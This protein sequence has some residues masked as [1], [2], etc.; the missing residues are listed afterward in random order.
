MLHA[1]LNTLYIIWENLSPRQ[2]VARRL[3]VHMLQKNS[4]CPMLRRVVAHRLSA[5]FAQLP[6]LM[7]TPMNTPHPCANFPSWNPI[8]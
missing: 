1:A 3:A 5:H 4:G 6:A 7:S 8:L 2:V